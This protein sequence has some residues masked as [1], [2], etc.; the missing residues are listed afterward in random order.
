MDI[1]G[2]IGYNCKYKLKI[3]GEIL[4]VE[5]IKVLV[6]CIICAY[7]IYYG[8][9]IPIFEYDEEY[10]GVVVNRDKN[11]DKGLYSISIKLD[12]GKIVIIDDRTFF[13]KAPDNKE[14]QVVY[15]IRKSLFKNFIDDSYSV[16]E[17]VL[18][19]E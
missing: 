16:K 4:A 9:T 10:I 11:N 1:K 17:S 6:F 3:K 7:A 8:L 5:I 13:M 14:F 12:N 18:E 2:I 15:K 19:W